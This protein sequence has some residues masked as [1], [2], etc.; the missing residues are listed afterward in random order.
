MAQII[1]VMR[2]VIKV[3]R[4]VMKMK[5]GIKSHKKN[6]KKEVMRNESRKENL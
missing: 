5:I 4:R 1:A 2:K 6:K 3:V